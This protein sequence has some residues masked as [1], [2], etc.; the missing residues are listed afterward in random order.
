MRGASAWLAAG[1]LA[2]EHLVHYG[3]DSARIW[4]F[5]HTV[6]TT[7]LSARA[8]ALRGHRSEIRTQFG[9]ERD[10]VV[11]LHA[12]RLLPI[13]G[14]DVL[15]GAA[16]RAGC[17]KLLIVGDGPE[18]AALE[19]ASRVAGLDAHFAGFLDGDNLI[20]AY[21]A[22]DIFTLLSRRE[23]WGVVV[24]EAAASGL[25]LVLSSARRS[26]SRHP[27]AGRERRSGPTYRH[28]RDCVGV[29]P[30]RA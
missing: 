2:R 28:R 7:T 29:A 25:P 19:H 23:T 27:G 17:V 11:V 22:A 24:N 12:G 21:V 8:D 20:K 18:R 30:T 9:F 26:R 6:D 13:K 10:D 1:T 14:V 15:I 4:T 5:A 16:T 3:A